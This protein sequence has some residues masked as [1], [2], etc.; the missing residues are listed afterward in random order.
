MYKELKYK[1]EKQN[2][3]VNTEKKQMRILI[4]F[5][6][7]SKDFLVLGFFWFVCWLGF[8]PTTGNLLFFL[9]LKLVLLCQIYLQIAF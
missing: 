7:T 9:D 6:N 3:Y 1:L 8:F 4:V 5:F 2:N